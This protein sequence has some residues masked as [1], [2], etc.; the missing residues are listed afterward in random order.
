[1]LSQGGKGILCDF[2]G[3]IYQNKFEYYPTEIYSVDART[4]LKYVYPPKLIG[5]YD[6]G[7]ICMGEYIERMKKYADRNIT[8][9]TIP[10][11]FCDKIM[12]GDFIYYYIKIAKLEVDVSKEHSVSDSIKN[13]MQ[14]RICRNCYKGIE[15]TI[16]KNKHQIKKHGEWT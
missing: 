14:M 5:E 6:M 3:T 13:F 1:M 10:C 8:R 2:T 15:A 9:T 7:H 16:K 4:S 12:S 11:D